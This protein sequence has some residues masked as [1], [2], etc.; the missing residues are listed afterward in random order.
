MGRQATNEDHTEPEAGRVMTAEV[1][2]RA[3]MSP[4]TLAGML[5]AIDMHPDFLAALLG[6]LSALHGAAD[7][8]AYRPTTPVF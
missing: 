5:A 3:T 2:A 4:E 6:E 1:P 7:R 8:A